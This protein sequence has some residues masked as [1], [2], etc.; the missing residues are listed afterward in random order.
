MLGK[1][2]FDR[3]RPRWLCSDSNSDPCSGQLSLSYLQNACIAASV[4][5]FATSVDIWLVM[6]STRWFVLGSKPVWASLCALFWF[7]YVQQRKLQKDY[8]KVNW[9]D[10]VRWLLNT[11]QVTSQGS[12]TTVAIT[13]KGLQEINKGKALPQEMLVLSINMNAQRKMDLDFASVTRRVRI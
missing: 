12:E 10:G 7:M 11:Q 5:Y 4:K 3:S 8:M 6:S 9:D 2:F 13:I 1:V